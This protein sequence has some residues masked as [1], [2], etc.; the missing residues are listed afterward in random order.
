MLK[1]LLPLIAA[2]KFKHQGQTGEDLGLGVV[3]AYEAARGEVNRPREDRAG[4]AA[5]GY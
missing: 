2:L 3:A 5:A 4:A 1:F